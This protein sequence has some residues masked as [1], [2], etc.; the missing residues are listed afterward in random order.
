M[1]QGI[2]NEITLSIQARNG[3]SPAVL[4]WSAV[5][6]FAVLAALV[7]LCV[8]GYAWFLL[9]FDPIVA[10]LIMAGIFAVVA[11]IAALIAALIRRQVRERAILARA[12]KAHSPSWL[13]DPRILGMAADA[14]RSIGWQRILPVALL[15]FVVAQWARDYRGQDK[16]QPQQ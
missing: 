7:F 15:G 10:G 6:G 1:L 12:A 16:Q 2:K 13:L 5:M 8:A 11:I 4:V 9:R 14:G 3:L